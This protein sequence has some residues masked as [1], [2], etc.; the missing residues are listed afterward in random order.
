MFRRGVDVCAD[1]S[2]VALC[3]FYFGDAE[4]CD[5][6]RLP[7]GREQQVLRL[8]VAMD[9]ARFVRVLETGRDLFEIEERAFEREDWRQRA[10]DR[11]LKFHHR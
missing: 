10:P 7:V 2:D 5:L 8:D 11:A 6:D 1:A 3:R 9:D 4:V